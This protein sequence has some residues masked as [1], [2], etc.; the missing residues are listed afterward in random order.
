MRHRN[1][2]ITNL[3]GGA[4]NL[5]PEANLNI[6]LSGAPVKDGVIIKKLN[7]LNHKNH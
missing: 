7:L 1:N 6:N 3:F 5:L 2:K 4:G